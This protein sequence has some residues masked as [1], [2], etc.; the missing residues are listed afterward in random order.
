[1]KD[2][3]VNTSLILSLALL[4]AIVFGLLLIAYE[5]GVPFGLY[6]KFNC[7]MGRH[8]YYVK[9]GRHRVAK[10]FCKYCKC[11]RNHPKL[12][13]LEGGANKLSDIKFR[14]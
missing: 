9:F 12:E 14:F 10:Y 5:D 3:D 2:I 8:A 7:K 6:R 13:L 11:K 4:F 1:M